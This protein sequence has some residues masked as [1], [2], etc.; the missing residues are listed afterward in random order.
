MTDQWD[1]ENTREVIQPQAWY[2]TKVLTCW[3]DIVFWGGGAW[4]WKTFELL[5][6]PIKWFKKIRFRGIIF[7]KTFVQIKGWGWLWDESVNIYSKI[8]WAVPNEAESKWVFEN[9]YM[10]KWEY[11]FLKF[12][13]L[14]YEKDKYSHQWL[15]Y[16]FIWF[17]ELTHF[18]ESQF[19]YLLSRNR[20]TCGIKPYVRCTCNPDPYSWVIKWI[21][22]YLDENWFIRP[23][24]D[25]VIRYF[26]I[27][28]NNL[29]WWDSPQEVVDKCPHIFNNLWPKEKPEDYIKSF[30]FIEWKLEDNQKLL[31]KDKTYKANLLAQDE[32]TKRALLYRCWKP[33][34][35]DL[36]LVDYKCL[37]SI[38]SNYLS[39]TWS[40]RYISADIA[41]LWKDLAVIAVWQWY[42]LVKL[43]IF[44]KSLPEDLL[45]AIESDRKHYQIP[46]HYVVYDNDGLGWG[47]AWNNYVS[48]KWW[49]PC[50]EYQG[51]KD[52][53]KNL[54]TQCYCR[55]I[56]DIINK[57]LMLITDKNIFIDWA[58]C[59]EIKLW[60]KVYS[61]I[62]LIKQD[63][64]AIRRILNDSEWKIQ[65]NPKSEQK[66]IL[67]RSPDF[68]DTIMMRFY[69]EL[70]KKKTV[71]IY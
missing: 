11:P 46:K 1:T 35:D 42:E 16:C 19:L 31:E 58:P 26:T 41:W 28:N 45:K 43:S 36:A 7:R 24:R 3:A 30:T 52:N 39:N 4:A 25:W 50:I 32:A 51:T 38:T 29:I 5:L 55:I 15:Q 66:N 63:L 20:S 65:I 12:S 10:S 53:Y 62:D 68:W 59:R 61:I 56:Q 8:P 40:K 33:L 2:Q 67:W 48:F 23:D 37:E 34:Q 60:N 6:E 9:P 44:T 64:R 18:T 27:D 54:K 21:E 71:L 70:M 57:D 22:R 17:D 69:F 13:H 14:E 49:S 47:L